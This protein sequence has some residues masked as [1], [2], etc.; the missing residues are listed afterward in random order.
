[1]KLSCKTGGL[2]QALLALS[3]LSGC[4]SL[5][6][7]QHDKAAVLSG[8][9]LGDLRMKVGSR[10]K[11]LRHSSGI[12]WGGYISGVAVADS[13]VVSVEYGSKGRGDRWD[14]EVY[15]LGLKPGVSAA[16]YMNRMGGI[17]EFSEGGLEES[18]GD[19]VFTIYVE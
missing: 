13:S 5:R 3:L 16:V 11:L 9:S 19:G 4:G 14:P 15:L 10:V 7:Y 18:D 8:E 12:M 6:Y 1:M 2:V 17:S